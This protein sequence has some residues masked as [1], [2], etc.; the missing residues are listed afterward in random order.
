MILYFQQVPD[1]LKEPFWMPFIVWLIWAGSFWG[2]PN[3]EIQNGGMQAMRRSCFWVWALLRSCQRWVP[4]PNLREL[5]CRLTA[6]SWPQLY[7]FKLYSGPWLGNMHTLVYVGCSL[8]TTYFS[9]RVSRGVE[10]FTG[11]KAQN[12]MDNL[13][14]TF[15]HLQKYYFRSLRGILDVVMC[16]YWGCTMIL[17]SPLCRSI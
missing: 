16:T 12:S 9:P 13:F 15:T 8:D 10:W 17:F 3:P 6:W 7:T 2:T 1:L 5:L 4:D 11:G 14:W